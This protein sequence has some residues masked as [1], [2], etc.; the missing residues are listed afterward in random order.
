MIV[1]NSSLLMRF[2]LTAFAGS[3]SSRIF[4]PQPCEPFTATSKRRNL[5]LW[6]L[7]ARLGPQYIWTMSKDQTSISSRLGLSF[8][9]DSRAFCAFP[10]DTPTVSDRWRAAQRLFSFPPH[11]WRDPQRTTI[12]SLMILGNIRVERGVPLKGVH[13]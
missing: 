13:K 3:I 4:P 5:F 12:D 11:P 9:R 6:Y 7:V 8:R 1:A 2:H 10:L